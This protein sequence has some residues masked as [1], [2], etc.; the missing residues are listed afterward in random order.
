MVQGVGGSREGGAAAA[1]GVGDG[2]ATDARREH[3]RASQGM[4][5]AALLHRGHGEEDRT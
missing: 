3:L 4:S 2:E 1:A 5:H